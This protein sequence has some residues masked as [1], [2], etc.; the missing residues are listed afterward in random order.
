MATRRASEGSGHGSG[1]DSSDTASHI[2]SN[3]SGLGDGRKRLGMRGE[4]AAVLHLETL[5]YEILA[6]NWRS[7]LGELDVVAR[8]GGT[9]V[10]V[11]VKLRY[12][13]LNPLEAVDARKRQRL[14]RLAFDFL[15][16]HCMLGRPARFDVIAVEGRTLVCTHVLYA[17]DS[18][19]DY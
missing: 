14:S 5:G 15:S 11:E 8:D 18:T 12:D 4:D 7:R 10:F 9:L 2:P 13:P 6:R 1:R 19:I 17:F 16:R 3:G